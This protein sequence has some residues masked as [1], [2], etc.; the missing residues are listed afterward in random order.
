MHD[1]YKNT[2]EYNP[3]K[4]N[5]ILIVFDDMIADMIHN[6]KLNSIVHCLLE[7]ENKIFLLFLLPNHILR[8]QKMLG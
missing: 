7:V 1:V 2:D 6:K 3:Y 8:F 4:E 5:K